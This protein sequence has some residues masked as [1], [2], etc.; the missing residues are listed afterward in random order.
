MPVS[1]SPSADRSAEN[2]SPNPSW[3]TSPILWGLAATFGF[4]AAIP[5][6]PG[7]SETAKRYF[8]SHPLEYL[9]VGLFC[10]GMA[11]L[12][13]RWWRLRSERAS[14]KNNIFDSL[15]LTDQQGHDVNVCLNDL[16]FALRDVPV[17]QRH[18]LL[19]V[20]LRNACEYVRTRQ[21]ARGLEEH[22]K[23]L[24]EAAIDRLFE[25]FS[26]LLTINWAVPI[27]G[28]LGTVI[29]ITLAIANVTP[30][31][32]DTS[33]NTVTGGLSVAFDTTTV[34]MSFSLILVFTY[35]WIK[36]SEQRLLADVEQISL[37]Q[38]LPLFLADSIGADPVHEAQTTAARQLLDRTESL[39]ED[40][41]T[42]W[43]DSMD[44]LRE[45]WSETLDAQ[46]QALTSHLGNGVEATLGEHASQLREV[47]QEF[48]GAFE[49]A[50]TQFQEA[51]EFDAAR[52]DLQSEQSQNQQQEMWNGIRESLQSVVQA[53]DARTE[54]LLEQLDERMQSWLTALESSSQRV[55]AQMQ[56]LA[57]FTEQ[58]VRLAD[59]EQQLIN[60]EQQLSTNLEAV[61]AAETFEETLH[62]L[63]AAVHLLTAR[64]KPKA[65]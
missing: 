31:Q 23:Y 6:L 62:N 32:L 10:V 11:M 61:R 28:F 7:Y 53:H 20:R 13:S 19:N 44:G 52:R 21:S 25:S 5:Y 2:S 65:A 22:L 14:V 55:D 24:S 60:V 49:K 3:W 48:L 34:A 33:L 38:L 58:L 16:D 30:E 8:C 46:Q 43:R 35:D 40:Q 26:L 1:Q 15:V 41:T 9:L 63:T 54:D 18:S 59:Q 17:S 57:G 36:R 27:I 50:S 56:Q 47:R 64:A 37:T 42:L 39:I 51:L 4:Y 45:R 12:I 29:G